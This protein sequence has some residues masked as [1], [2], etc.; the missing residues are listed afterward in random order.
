VAKLLYADI[1]AEKCRAELWLN[2]IPLALVT[3]PSPYLSVAAH[4]YVVDGENTLEIVVNPGPEPARARD[5]SGKSLP[6]NASVHGRLS[7]LDPGQF[8]DDPK[9]PALIRADWASGPPGEAPKIVAARS[10]LGVMFGPW[11]WQSAP[12]LTLDAATVAQVEAV[13][14]RIR[15]SLQQG[16]A[17]VLG[18]LARPKFEA[19]ARAF[20][21]RSLQETLRQFIAVVERNAKTPGWSM[22]PLDPAK[23]SFRL[24]AGGRLIECVNKDWKA[25][26]RSIPPPGSI[27]MYFP[28]FVGMSGAGFAVYL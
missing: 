8:T 9:A 1:M 17:S 24:V 13:L 4:M 2:D 15:V 7:A 25:T 12:R 16:D 3:E 26:I 6:E 23:F 14:E 19:A 11:A 10:N 20:P 5:R 27:P 28:M 18:R 21:A 22:L